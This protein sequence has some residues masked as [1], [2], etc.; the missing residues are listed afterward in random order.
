MGGVEASSCSGGT[1]VTSGTGVGVAVTIAGV[2]GAVICST[3]GVITGSSP[4]GRI[5]TISIDGSSAGGESVKDESMSNC[6]S[7]VN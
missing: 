7:S 5:S 3:G 4:F 1:V 6:V 2:G